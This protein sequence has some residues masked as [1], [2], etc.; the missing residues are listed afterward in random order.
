MKM[1]DG[2]QMAIRWQLDGNQMAIR[3]Q[4]DGNYS[5]Q[6]LICSAI[7]SHN[8]T[9]YLLLNIKKSSSIYFYR[10]NEI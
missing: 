10:K 2:N 7:F 1:G 4:L 9:C 3:W 5:N 6:L 8:K